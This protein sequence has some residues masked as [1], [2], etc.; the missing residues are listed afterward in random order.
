MKKERLT[1][2]SVP[3]DFS[4]RLALVDA[5]PVVFFGIDCILLYRFFPHI[6]FLLGAILSLVSGAVKVIWKILVAT[7]KKNIWPLF[8]QMR[9]AMPIGFVMMIGSLVLYRYELHP[10]LIW[11]RVS[12][13]PAVIFFSLGALGMALML[14]FAV[15]LNNRSR[16]ANWVEQLTNGLA[17]ICF[18]IGLLL[19]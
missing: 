5:I 12:G 6:L 17:Q 14:L 3:E 15:L 7:K 8:I 16:K 4:V 10:T 9:I 13:M 1:K 11:Q 19:I 18:L 2:D